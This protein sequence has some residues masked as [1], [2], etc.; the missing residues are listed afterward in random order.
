MPLS[1]YEF[2]RFEALE[3]L[4][5][6]PGYDAS[7]SLAYYN[8]WSD[9]EEHGWVAIFERDGQFFQ[10]E[11]GYSP[12]GGSIEEKLFYEPISLEQALEEIDSMEA[13]CAE[14]DRKHSM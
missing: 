3:E 13:T 2:D 7:Y 12:M 9:Y 10:C 6:L 4:S 5:K 11:G 14:M 1:N 8:G